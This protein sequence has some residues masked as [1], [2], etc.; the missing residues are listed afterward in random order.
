M[1]SSEHEIQQEKNHG[2][3]DL[4]IMKLQHLMIH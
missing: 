4:S 1:T 2:M 3:S